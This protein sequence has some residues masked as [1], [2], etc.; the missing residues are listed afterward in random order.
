VC[1]MKPP[2]QARLGVGEELADWHCHTL[3]GDAMH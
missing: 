3:H 2:G 1:M